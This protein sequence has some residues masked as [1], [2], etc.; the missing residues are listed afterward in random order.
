MKEAKIEKNEYSQYLRKDLF[1]SLG[2]S[3][4]AIALLVALYYFWK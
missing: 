3:I 1:K 2:L 4:V